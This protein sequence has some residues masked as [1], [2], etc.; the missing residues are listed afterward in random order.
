MHVVF[1]VATDYDVW[2]LQPSRINQCF[3]L[4]CHILYG[5]REDGL[6]CALFVKC[7]LSQRGVRCKIRQWKVYILCERKIHFNKGK[8]LLAVKMATVQVYS[9]FLLM[10]E[11]LWYFWF[12]CICI[13]QIKHFGCIVPNCYLF[14][15]KGGKCIYFSRR[16]VIQKKKWRTNR[17][18]NPTLN[19]L[20][21]ACSE[22]ANCPEWKSSLYCNMQNGFPDVF[23]CTLLFNGKNKITL[24]HSLSTENCW[25]NKDCVRGPLQRQNL[26]WDAIYT[27]MRAFKPSRPFSLTFS[28][29]FK[30]RH[31][32]KRFH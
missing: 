2:G 31:K 5:F 6:R 24:Q 12:D 13:A 17:Q 18:K 23:F 7:F 20:D 10:Y 4:L 26:R 27:V 3:S 14:F 32:L 22:L 21:G 29:F 15:F 16:Y 19:F 8:A 9:N 25:E 11:N 30:G 1:L 28:F